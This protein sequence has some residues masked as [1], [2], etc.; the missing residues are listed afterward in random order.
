[1]IQGKWGKVAHNQEGLVVT[2]EIAK[3][4]IGEEEKKAVLAVLESGHLVQGSYVAMLEDRFAAAHGA[5]YAVATSSGTAALTAAL[6]AHEISPG[7]EV[8]VPAFSFFASASSVM[9]VGARP[10]FADIEPDT[11]N[12]SV[13]AA[14]A[15]ITPRTRAIMPVHLYGHPADMDRFQALCR[16]KGLVLV[17]DAAQAHAAAIGDRP[18]GTWGTAAFSFY[19][20]KNMTTTEGGM[21]LTSDVDVARRLRMIRNQGRNNQGLHEILGFNFRMTDICGAIGVQ[22]LAR[23]S[24]W[25]SLRIANAAYYSERLTRVQTPIVRKGCRHVFHQYT[26]RVPAGVNRD[27]MVQRLNHRGIGVRVYYPLPIYQQPA[28]RKI[29]TTAAEERPEAERAAREVFSLPVHHQLTQMELDT[30]VQEVNAAC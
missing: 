11:Y 20:T 16:S 21:V 19:A 4:Y 23:L 8:I 18:V 29:M 7:D 5:K 15:A 26:V 1:M 17:E 27:S 22:Q 30:V 9:S 10:V 25:T 28:I 24:D 14:E 6:L 2:I 13:L 12:L 3:P